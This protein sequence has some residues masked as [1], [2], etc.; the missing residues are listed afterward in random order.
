[1]TRIGALLMEAL[2]SWTTA[3]AASSDDELDELLA[4]WAGEFEA[5]PGNPSET[6]R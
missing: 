4:T 6:E 5:T 3:H 2:L 1:M